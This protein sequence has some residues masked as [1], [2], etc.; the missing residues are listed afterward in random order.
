MEIV[1]VGGGAAGVFAA[2]TA[3]AAAPQAR[4]RL[5]EA[6]R[7][8]LGKVKISGG[9][10]CNVT[11]HCF[12]PALLVQH[13]PR[14][15]RALRGPFSRFQPQDTVAWFAQR[16]VPL[17]TEADGRMFPTTDDSQTIIDCLLGEAR[18]LGVAV[19]CGTAV[20][21]VSRQGS[22]F[23]LTLARGGSVNCDRLLLA[24]G[25]TPGGYRLAQRLGHTLVPPVPSLFTFTIADGP[26]RQLAGI[27]VDPVRLTLAV[28]GEKPRPQ[29]GPLLI[30]HWGLSGPAVLKLSAFA[31]PALHRQG[32]QADL[33]VNWLPEFSLAEVQQQLQ[34]A[35][36]N[37]GKRQVGTYCP[38]PLPRRLWQYWLV[39]RLNL[40]PR[41][42]WANLSKAVLHQL[43]TT[44]SRS[45]YRVAGKGAFKDEFVTCGGVSLREVNFK[46]M[47]S[48]VCPGLHLAGELLDIDGVT[49]GF[50]FQ[51]A[52]TTGY[53]AGLA[54]ADSAS[55]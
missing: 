41:T 1:V 22:G 17:K 23:E 50:N 54:L 3:A 4:V 48:R 39:H 28:E 37:Q 25:S 24:T 31:A 13:Y 2:L 52:W 19:R 10:R 21:Q 33:T 6:A 38:F 14:G 27:S 34:Q 29:D 36:R 9:G 45:P 40:D 7:T 30:C 53:L 35:K 47:A 8:P 44:V 20:R 51:N 15:S 18:R 32:Y 16:G 46:T 55:T 11:H 5:L 49:G 26:L 43:A 12:D 42:T